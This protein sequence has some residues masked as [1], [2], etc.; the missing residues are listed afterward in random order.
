MTCGPAPT[1]GAYGAAGGPID[2]TLWSI[3]L[4]LWRPRL[5]RL[6]RFSSRWC[7]HSL[8]TRGSLS[9]LR[10]LLQIEIGAPADA[11]G[12]S[13]ASVVNRREKRRE[14]PAMRLLLLRF[15]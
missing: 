4:G 1:E 11:A 3:R 9:L 15:E 2:R 8:H 12:C 7:E 14:E 13:L 10:P 5:R 6:S